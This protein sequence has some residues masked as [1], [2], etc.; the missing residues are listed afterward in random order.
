MASASEFDQW[1][2]LHWETQHTV[3]KNND[4]YTRRGKTFWVNKVSGESSWTMP[5]ALEAHPSFVEGIAAKKRRHQEPPPALDDFIRSVFE[6]YSTK[7]TMSF[8]QFWDAFDD[9]LHLTCWLKAEEKVKLADT[10]DANKDGKVSFDEFVDAI[11]PLLKTAFNSRG[12]SEWC[13]MLLSPLLFRSSIE[14]SPYRKST[15]ALCLRIA[16]E[17]S[18]EGVEYL[19]W[20]NRITG[21]SSWFAPGK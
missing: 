12:G 10:V 2:Q 8:A 21:E 17:T 16:L 5:P 7:G 20:T 15:V 6:K 13:V 1:K 4:G 9:E 11:V 18:Y 3:K 14:C 19:Y